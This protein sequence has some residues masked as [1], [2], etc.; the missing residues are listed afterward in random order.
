MVDPRPQT[1]LLPADGLASPCAAARA[2]I[3]RPIGINLNSYLGSLPYSTLPYEIEE[4]ITEGISMLKP[5]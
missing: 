3:Q 5:A 4:I 1:V 2:A